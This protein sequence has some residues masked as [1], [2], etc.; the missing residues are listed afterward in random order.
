MP[1]LKG[2]A[3]ENRI[4]RTKTRQFLQSGTEGTKVREKKERKEERKKKER[5]NY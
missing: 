2:R 1:H 4:R 5:K 3:A